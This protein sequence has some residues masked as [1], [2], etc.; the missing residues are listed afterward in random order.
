MALMDGRQMSKH[1]A[2]ATVSITT[3]IKGESAK[4]FPRAAR[5]R[6]A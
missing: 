3:R 2:A 4:R 1:H 5:T 6:H